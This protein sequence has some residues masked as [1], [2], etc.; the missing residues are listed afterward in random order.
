MDK[1]IRATST[2]SLLLFHYQEIANSRAHARPWRK[3]RSESGG[4]LF[5]ASASI[6]GRSKLW[7]LPLPTPA[8]PFP[9]HLKE[10]FHRGERGE[11]N[12]R[13]GQWERKAPVIP[14]AKR[15]NLPFEWKFMTTP[16]ESESTVL[17]SPSNPDNPFS[18]ISAG[19]RILP[20]SLLPLR[21]T[22]FQQRS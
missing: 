5:T 8:F 12:E 13:N 3:E 14:V 18:S 7:P 17:K 16:L 19:S 6:D 2:L 1:G 9:L 4:Y 20:L 11:N 10:A 22:L 21:Q 15:T